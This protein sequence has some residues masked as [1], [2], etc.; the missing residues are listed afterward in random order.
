MRRSSDSQLG[1]D[2]FG[3]R[4]RGKVGLAEMDRVGLCKQGQVESIIHDEAGAALSGQLADRFRPGERF[5]VWGMLCSKLNDRH[6]GLTCL[7]GLLNR[8]SSPSRIVV[9]ENVK[10]EIVVTTLWR[11]VRHFIHVESPAPIRV[12]ASRSRV[13]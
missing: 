12:W 10:A 3:N 9:R 13:R 11:L 5:T 2:L 1:S 6:T 4:A 7:L 8:I